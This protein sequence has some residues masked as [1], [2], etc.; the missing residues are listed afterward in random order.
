MS[1]PVTGVDITIFTAQEK[2]INHDGRLVEIQCGE[3]A[4]LF[5]VEGS[6]NAEQ[7]G[8]SLVKCLPN[9]RWRTDED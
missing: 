4:M 5:H 2:V 6:D 7:L 1:L 9:A 8:A 3:A